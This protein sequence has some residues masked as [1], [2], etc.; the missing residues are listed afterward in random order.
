MMSDFNECL[1]CLD[2]AFRSLRSVTNCCDSQ[3]RYARQ[4]HVA[5]IVGLQTKNLIIFFRYRKVEPIW[6]M[7][8]PPLKPQGSTMRIENS[9]CGGKESRIVSLPTASAYATSAFLSERTCTCNNK[10]SRPSRNSTLPISVPTFLK[11]IT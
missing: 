4:T 5:A 8:N 9:S 3:H 10:Q 7:A 1:L 2:I 6:Y 11:N